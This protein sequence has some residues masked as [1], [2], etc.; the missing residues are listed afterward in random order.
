MGILSKIFG[1]KKREKGI[2]IGFPP[3]WGIQPPK[4]IILLMENLSLLL[5]SD[6]ILY[7]EGTLM[8]QVEESLDKY[9]IDNPVFI[10]RGTLWPKP[11]IHH[12]LMKNE[13]IEELIGI[14]NSGVA[15]YPSVHFHAYKNNK[16]LIYWHDAFADNPMIVSVD[17][18]EDT[19][20]NYCSAINSS[21]IY[22]EE[23][24]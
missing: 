12:V 3:W 20:K 10:E 2:D 21:Y 6:S 19:V 16:I 5:P 13:L 7:F 24:R 18:K 11:D 23:K 1:I 4:D 22:Y 17:I 9:E 8:K 14:I 15:P